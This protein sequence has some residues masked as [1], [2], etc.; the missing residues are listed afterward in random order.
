[1]FVI[2]ITGGIG[3]GK[4][5]VARRL[6]AWG[7][8][9]L[10]ADRISHE[11]SG[12]GGRAKEKITAL[13]GAGILDEHGEIVRSRLAEIV[14]HNRKDLDALSMIVHEEVM[15]EIGERLAALRKKKAPLAVLDV[16]IP[17]KDGFLNRCD[18]IW[19]VS[20]SEEL[21]VQRLLA[22]GLK[23][24][25]IRARMAMQMPP[26]KYAELADFLIDNSGDLETLEQKTDEILKRELGARGIRLPR[27]SPETLSADAAEH[28][29]P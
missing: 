5:S 21:R 26:E 15:A 6:A 29:R 23:E 2:G 4:S 28:K 7:L 3:S 14:F 1:M 12:A 19:V 25:D 11:V 10:D 22:R 16:P 20:A 24:A 17:V 18:Q 13:F 27:E 9:V 8:P